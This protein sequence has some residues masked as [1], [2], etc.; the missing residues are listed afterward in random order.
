MWKIV[1]VIGM[2]LFLL[3]CSMQDIREKRISVKMLVLFGILFLVMS[4]LFDQI[5]IEQRMCNMLPGMLAF[6]LAFFT[7]EQFG[8]GDA[9]CLIVLGNI[10]YSDVLWGAIMGG[11][12][13][14]SVCSM[15]LLAGKKADRKTTLPF[16]PFLSAGVLW[17]TILNNI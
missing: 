16:L 12:V 7:K 14:F 13:L 1:K 5:S 2:S 17:Q 3:L 4:L 6:L 9:A 15:V 8:Y 10:I 11:L